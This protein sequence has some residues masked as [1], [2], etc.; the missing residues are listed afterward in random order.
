[1]DTIHMSV[2]LVV[3]DQ[4]ELLRQNLPQFLEIAEAA[5]AEIIVV[6]D[7]SNDETSDVLQVMRNDNERLYTT[8]LPQS[9]VINPSRLRLAMAVGV[10]A[11]KGGRIVFAD[12]RRPPISAEWLTGL[13]EGNAALVYTNRQREAVT[14]VIATALDDL[15]TKVLK[16]ERRG[17]HLHDAKWRK[18]HR[19]A[20]DALCVRREEAFDAI[21]WFDQKIGGMKLLAL[22]LDI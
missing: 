3:H 20:Y 10:K 2:I 21:Q 14:H 17:S 8:F 18:I 4:A 5:E 7:M 13:D 9:V 15:K 19:G 6:D 16:A 22:R 11:A 12:I 1:M